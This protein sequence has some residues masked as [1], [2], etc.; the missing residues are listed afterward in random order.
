MAKQDC[1]THRLKFLIS[2]H[3]S[4]VILISWLPGWLWGV[5]TRSNGC[6]CVI[7]AD[8][9]L[10]VAVALLYNSCHCSFIDL[11]IVL[12]KVSE[13]TVHLSSDHLFSCPLLVCILLHFAWLKSYH[14][15]LKFS[16]SMFHCLLNV[17]ILLCTKHHRIRFFFF[18][19]A[20]IL[21][22]KCISFSLICDLLILHCQFSLLLKSCLLFVCHFLVIH[23]AV[24]NWIV[25]ISYRSCRNRFFE[26]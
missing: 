1:H 17:K 15:M 10:L 12:K 3:M 19:I 9:Y 7:S 13:I 6:D 26:D 11:F 14:S 2:I 20:S 23:R 24:W 21:T 18:W 5:C 16:I 4:S 8:H 22:W 25:A